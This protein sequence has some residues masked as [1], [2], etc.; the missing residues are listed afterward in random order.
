MVSHQM[1]NDMKH[2]AIVALGALLAAI[3]LA[4]GLNRGSARSDQL[5]AVSPPIIGD[6]GAVP[7]V[8]ELFTSEGCSSCPPAD[9]LLMRL[10]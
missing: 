6:G 10:V 3:L 4:I 8:V 2:Q 9:E 1:G 5:E 7:V